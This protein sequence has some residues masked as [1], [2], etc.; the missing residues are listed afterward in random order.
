LAFRLMSYAMKDMNFSTGI[1]VQTP[2]RAPATWPLRI[3]GVLAILLAAGWCAAATWISLRYI[4]DLE[5]AAGM[6]YFLSVGMG[7]GR[8]AKP[9]DP[10]VTV[11]TRLSWL[12]FM[13]VVSLWTAT[14]GL[15][16][17][18]AKHA[19]VW[20]LRVAGVFV[21]L[22]TASTLAGI[23]ILIHFGGFPPMPAYTIALICGCQSVPGVFFLAV[24]GR[25]WSPSKTQGE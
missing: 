10:T 3:V 24:S 15:W 12:A 7:G 9:F 8:P 18:R 14:A 16:A 19:A 22:A 4:R 2:P 5:I 21:L 1:Q 13:W 11:V 6:A 23:E 25:R 20:M 17:L